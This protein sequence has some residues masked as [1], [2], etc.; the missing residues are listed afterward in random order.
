MNGFAMHFETV[1][2]GVKRLAQWTTM[3]PIGQNH[4]FYNITLSGSCMTV[5]G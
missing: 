1:F 2:V 3:P 5:S 4:G